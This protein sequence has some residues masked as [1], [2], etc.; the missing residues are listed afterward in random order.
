MSMSATERDALIQ[1][2]ALRDDFAGAVDERTLEILDRRRRMSVVRRLSA[3]AR[4]TSAGA[5]A[6]A[7]SAHVAR[8]DWGAHS[9]CRSGWRV[10]ISS[11]T[12]RSAAT[13]E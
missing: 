5:K 12:A 8:N 9:A 2:V 10:R 3:V 1:N 11:C 4:A 13:R 7:I 6:D